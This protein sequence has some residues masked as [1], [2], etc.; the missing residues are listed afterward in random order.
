MI[1]IINLVGNKVKLK[2]PFNVAFPA[3]YLVIGI[4]DNAPDTLRLDL[5]G[6]G[7]PC[8]FNIEFIEVV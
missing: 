2:A 1:D 6:D 4:A 3:S 5:Y 7:T 8:D